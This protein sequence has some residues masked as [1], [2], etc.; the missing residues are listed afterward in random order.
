MRLVFYQAKGG[1]FL[2]NN[3]ELGLF[4]IVGIATRVT[5]SPKANLTHERISP[6][7][8][9]G[10]VNILTLDLVSCYGIR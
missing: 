7:N 5:R 3:G 8:S 6:K 10:N 1:F 4:R 2:R 9:L